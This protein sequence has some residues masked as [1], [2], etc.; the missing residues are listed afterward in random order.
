MPHPDGLPHIFVD[1]SLGRIAVPRLL[2][3]A[4]L[5]LTT[6]AEHYGIPQDEN[7]ADVTWLTDTAQLGWVA[8]MKDERI[9][10]RPGEQQAVRTHRARCFYLTRQNLPG[11]VMADWLL[12][13]LP[14]IIAACA[15]PGPF[16]Y[17]VHAHQ[18][19]KMDLD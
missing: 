16:L 8:F 17:A 7:I 9:R 13:N 4:G 19:K 15:R 1:R 14:A 12:T 3:D 2:R 6:L 18:I 5:E 10:R 11:T